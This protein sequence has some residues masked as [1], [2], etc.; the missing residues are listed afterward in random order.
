MRCIENR[1]GPKLTFFAVDVGHALD[2]PN[3]DGNAKSPPLFRSIARWERRT[4]LAAAVSPV[5]T[6]NHGVDFG[7]HGDAI[8]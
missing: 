1:N 4:T 5:A 3:G 7:L 2:N 8:F 6:E